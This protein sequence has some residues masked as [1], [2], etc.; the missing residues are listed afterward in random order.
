MLK[1]EGISEAMQSPS[2]DPRRGGFAQSCWTAADPRPKPRA[3][4]SRPVLSPLLPWAA[5][6]APQSSS[7]SKHRKH[8]GCPH[9]LVGSSPGEPR[10]HFR[11]LPGIKGIRIPLPPT[12]AGGLRMKGTDFPAP[13]PWCPGHHTHFFGMFY[14]C[15]LC[16]CSRPHRCRFLLGARTE[17]QT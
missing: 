7:Y 3:H 16:I 12:T 5:G 4:D 15:R 9:P 17:S 8:C 1:P 10:F 11:Q 14:S 6:T 13:G 2:E